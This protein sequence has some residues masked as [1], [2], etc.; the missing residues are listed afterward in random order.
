MKVMKKKKPINIKYISSPMMVKA[1]SASEF[2]AIVQQHTGQNPQ[3][4]T[5]TI[6]HPTTI[7]KTTK[8]ELVTGFSDEAPNT[9]QLLVNAVEDTLLVNRMSINIDHFDN[10]D[11]WF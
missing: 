3:V 10:I 6:R 5:S 4:K 7:R 9:K 11:T 8:E 2:R 1:S